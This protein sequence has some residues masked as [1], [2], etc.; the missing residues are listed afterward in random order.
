MFDKE[1]FQKITYNQLD[2]IVKSSECRVFFLYLVYQEDS[3]IEGIIKKLRQ[4]NVNG[5]INSLKILPIWIFNG[6]NIM[7]FESKHLTKILWM[8][9]D[10]GFAFIS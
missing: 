6:G 9:H 4:K 3:V 2:N 7:I 8:M 5:I 1:Y 10:S